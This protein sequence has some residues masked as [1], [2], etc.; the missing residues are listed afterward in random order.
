LFVS[1]PKPDFSFPKFKMALISPNF[2]K[3]SRKYIKKKSN[4]ALVSK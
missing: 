4:F 1:A 2:L 3:L